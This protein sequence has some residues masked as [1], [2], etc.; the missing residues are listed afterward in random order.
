[1]RINGLEIV[2]LVEVIVGVLLTVGVV[3]GII[4]KVMKELTG[5]PIW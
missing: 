2:D 4:I 1:M 5:S 3:A